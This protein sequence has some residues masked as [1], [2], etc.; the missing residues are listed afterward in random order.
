VWV[1]GHVV[2]HFISDTVEAYAAP[3]SMNRKAKGWGRVRCGPAEETIFES[4]AGICSVLVVGLFVLTFLAQNMVIPSGSM[5][6]TLLVGVIS[7]S[8]ASR[9]SALKVD[10]LV[11]Y[12]EPKR[13]DIVVF[14]RR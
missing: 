3:D 2:L 6:D 11:H 12:R 13:G 1:D 5:E 8:T 10:A 14:K 9:S 4:L 7:S